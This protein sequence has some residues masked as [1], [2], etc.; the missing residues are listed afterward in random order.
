MLVVCNSPEA[1]GEV[2]ADWRPQVDP[3]RGKR[4]AA[5]VPKQPARDWQ[6]LQSEPLYQAALETIA[7]LTV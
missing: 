4:V 3:A 1:V 5:L 7:R 6:A 2:L